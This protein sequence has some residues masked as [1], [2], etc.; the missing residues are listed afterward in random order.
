MI[1]LRA[2]ET[3]RASVAK[4]VQDLANVVIRL[5]DSRR[6]YRR[7]LHRL[8]PI[9][10]ALV[11]RPHFQRPLLVVDSGQLARGNSQSC[12]CKI[13]VRRRAFLLRGHCKRQMRPQIYQMATC[14]WVNQADPVAPCSDLDK[15]PLPAALCRFGSLLGTYGFVSWL[16]RTTAAFGLVGPRSNCYDALLKPLI[17]AFRCL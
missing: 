3:N 17:F 16:R 15:T 11:L 1:V 10:K 14:Y 5:R 6:F 4:L 8:P 2:T 12:A 7:P 13:C 9:P